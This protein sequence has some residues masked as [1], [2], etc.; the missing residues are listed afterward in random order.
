[1]AIEDLVRILPLASN[2]RENKGIDW[3]V[4][5][6]Q[7]QICLPDFYKKFISLYTEQD[8]SI[9]FLWILNPHSS[10]VNLNFEKS[11]YFV[12]AYEQMRGLFPND[13]ERAQGS[14]FPWGVTD[15]GDS[16]FWSTENGQDIWQVG[17][18]SSDQGEEELFDLDTE[19]FLMALIKRSLVSDIL[20]SD[21]LA[22][23]MEFLPF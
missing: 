13:Y 15:N 7:Y 12:E 5:E 4:I 14:F 9:R 1:M 19:G 3:V 8:L 16:I 17:V 10:N 22:S 2:P 21:F 6:K 20:P 23:D 11:L 18:H